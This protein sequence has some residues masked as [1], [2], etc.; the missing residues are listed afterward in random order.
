MALLFYPDENDP[1]HGPKLVANLCLGPEEAGEREGAKT[2]GLNY[3]H[4]ARIAAA[5]CEV[6]RVFRAQ[7][8]LL[9]DLLEWE[10]VERVYGS[11]AVALGNCAEQA[12]KFG[13]LD[14]NA[15]CRYGN[16]WTS[17]S[18]SGSICPARSFIRNLRDAWII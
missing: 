13:I 14:T 8:L 7:V 12:T 5:K 2:F 3:H 18:S 4:P 9:I 11:L 15:S 17:Q 1:L 6:K 16:R 10:T